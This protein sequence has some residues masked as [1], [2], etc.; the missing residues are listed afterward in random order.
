MTH[1]HERDDK[2][3]DQVDD[4]ESGFCWGAEAIGAVAVTGGVA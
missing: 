4:V 3:N 1:S 2:V